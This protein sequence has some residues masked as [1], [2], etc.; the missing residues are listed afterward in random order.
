LLLSAKESTNLGGILADAYVS[1][2]SKVS[3]DPSLRKKVIE[4]V[5]MAPPILNQQGLE[6]FP[7]GEARQVANRVIGRTTSTIGTSEACRFLLQNADRIDQP[8]FQRRLRSWHKLSVVGRSE[9]IYLS[10]RQLATMGKVRLHIPAECYS[11]PGPSF[12]E[13]DSSEP[14]AYTTQAEIAIL[15]LASH[16]QRSYFESLREI[17][18]KE[19]VRDGI[20]HGIVAI[21]RYSEDDLR[22]FESRIMRYG[23]FSAIERLLGGLL[24]P[25]RS[26]RSLLDAAGTQCADSSRMT[27]IR[28]LAEEI[29]APEVARWLSL[30]LNLTDWAIGET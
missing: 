1:A 14:E 19:W 30:L 15:A 20:C 28:C 22:K 26:S 10:F 2:G 8:Q 11:S 4:R 17:F 13:D 25:N 29:S 21:S 12:I 27:T 18:A 3:Q 7:E 6:R 9:L 23:G 5:A 24:G 16:L